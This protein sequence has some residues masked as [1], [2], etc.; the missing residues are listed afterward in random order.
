L[1]LHHPHRIRRVDA[2]GD[3]DEVQARVR[4][5]VEAEFELFSH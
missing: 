3:Q 4:S 5:V 2:R 1:L